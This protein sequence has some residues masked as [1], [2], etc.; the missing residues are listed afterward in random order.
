MPSHG[1][2]GLE[3]KAHASVV[4]DFRNRHK[5]T[6]F[7]VLSSALGE[8]GVHV[9]AAVSESLHGRISAK[10]LMKRLALR[11]GGRDDFAQGGGVEPGEVEGL[12]RRA[13]DVAREILEGVRA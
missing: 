2:E 8:K 13:A 3:R 12:R 1:W 9:I 4:D 11:G 7:L 10:D 6:A 5:D